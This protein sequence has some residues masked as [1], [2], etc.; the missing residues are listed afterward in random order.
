VSNVLNEEKRQQVLALGQLGW[1]LR[2]IQQATGVRRETASAY[3]K[4]AGIA[5]RPPGGWGKRPPTSKPANGVSPDFGADLATSTTAV[6]PTAAPTPAQDSTSLD[7]K[8][9]NEVS[10]DFGAELAASATAVAPP[11]A[12]TSAQ[13]AAPPEPKPANE[14]STDPAPG[15][16]VTASACEPYRDF[17]E[18]SLS[19]GRNAKAIYQDLVDDHG[20]AGRYASVKRFVRHCRGTQTPEARAVI[21][22]PPGEESQVDYGAGPMVRD[23][24]SGCYRRTRLFVLTLGYSRKCIRLLT[25]QSSTRTWAELHEQAFRRLGGATKTIVLDNLG[26]GVLKP[27]IYDPALNPVYRDVLAHYG[28]VA[29][30]CRVADPDRKGKVE[31]GVGHAKNTPLKGQR[32]ESLEEAQAYLDRWEAHW[33]DTRIHGTVKRQV[34][35]MFAE[36]KPALT[37]LPL[38]PFRHYQFGERRV[39][40]D[41]CVEVEA[42]YYSAPPG[43]IGRSVKV[44]WDGRVVR[45]IDPRS[46]QLLREHLRQERGKHRIPE[47]D[48]PAKTPRT[49]AQL[50]ARC[51]MIGP[52]VGTLAQRMYER[53]G[54]AEIR[55]ILGIT[56]LARQHGAAVTDH[57]CAGALDAGVPE[58][59][60]R[61][62]FRWLKHKTPLT[63]RQVDPIIRQLTLYRDF[64]DQKTQENQE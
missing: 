5:V 17:I 24:H 20:F 14:V 39:N 44:Q 26:E 22:T 43:W 8:P 47:Q 11:A 7:S 51:A 12:P 63:L 60:Y 59:P 25:F 46:G 9:A 28:A 38:E 4:A 13:G 16:N 48:K 36:E 37:P 31:R 50:L 53:G 41:G 61:F 45:V 62:V 64:I 10:T 57:A 27:D 32:F 40:L 21:L 3:L 49:T 56:S 58:N 6:A 55:R 34:A 30:P 52:H 33:A 23:P 35:A 1:A 2:R 42:A 18:L 19:K 29:L 15:P 54:Q